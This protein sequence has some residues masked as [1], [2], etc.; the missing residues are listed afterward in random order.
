MERRVSVGWPAVRCDVA[1][2]A[3]LGFT[4]RSIQRVLWLLVLDYREL[5]VQLVKWAPLVRHILR[6]LPSAPGAGVFTRGVVAGSFGVPLFLLEAN[7]RRGFSSS[8]EGAEAD[9]CKEVG[10]SLVVGAR[11][12][13]SLKIF[14][15][16]C[17]PTL[18][19][20]ELVAVLLSRFIPQWTRAFGSVRRSAS[21]STDRT[22]QSWRSIPRTCLTVDK[23]S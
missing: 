15:S 14:I 17:A 13:K 10:C 21:V 5:E 2:L 4:T 11:F 12:L 1:G 7:A 18:T 20:S 23:K 9:L 16:I 8:S 3:S 19:E 22:R 6:C